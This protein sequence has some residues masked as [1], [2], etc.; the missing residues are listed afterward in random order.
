MGILHLVLLVSGVNVGGSVGDNGN[1]AVSG[2]APE[3]CD[4]CECCG[5]Y[6]LEELYG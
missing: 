3:P 4:R 2:D 6:A 1:L 5:L